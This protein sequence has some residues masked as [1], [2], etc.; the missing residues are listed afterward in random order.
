MNETTA[1]APRRGLPV[2]ILTAAGPISTMNRIAST[3]GRAVIVKVY[4][5]PGIGGPSWTKEAETA[6]ARAQEHITHPGVQLCAESDDRPALALVVRRLRGGLYVHA[7]PADDPHGM[8][9]Q[10]GGAY[11]TY[12]GALD[13]LLRDL[14]SDGHYQVGPVPLHDRREARS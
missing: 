11:V 6:A 14:F 4:A 12:G 10:H 7:A 2:D 13:A 3:T 8:V 5:Q 9:G 1:P